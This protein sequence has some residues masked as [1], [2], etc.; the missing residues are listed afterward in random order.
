MFKIYKVADIEVVALRGLDLRL[1]RGELVAVVGASGSGKSTLLNILAGLDQPS[2][3]RV[4]VGERDLA[5]LS[6]EDLVEY[7]RREVGFVWQETA[8]NLVPYLDA[9]ENVALPLLLVG[10]PPAVAR[11]RA[12]ELL[13]LV[14]LASR[15][16][17]RPA[18]LS[19]GEQQRVAIAIALANQPP[20]LLADEP[21]GELDAIAADSV[22]ETFARVNRELGTTILVVTHDPDI[23]SRVH[24][25]VGIR[26][27]RTSYELIR[28][29]AQ[30]G[31][32]PGTSHEEYVLVDA[33]GRLQLPRE[34]LDALEIRERARVLLGEGYI[35][36]EP[37]PPDVDW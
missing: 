25:V 34:A 1:R 29:P 37:P 3:G 19:G 9:R 5:S 27:G 22:F 32:G 13:E 23:A 20:L 12:T 30:R 6:V 15:A 7:R 28:R 18:E 36:I 4:F 10:T 8:R 26:D 14:G 17:H 33:H 21:T 35:A 24:R 11:R 16:R 31:T 2:A